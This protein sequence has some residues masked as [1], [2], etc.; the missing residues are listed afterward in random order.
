MP[1]LIVIL[2]L[3]DIV[4]ALLSLAVGQY[5]RLDSLYELQGLLDGSTFR[6]FLYVLIVLLACYFCELYAVDRRMPRTE[7]A[8]RLSVAMMVAFFVLSALFYAVP[9][10]NLGR[11]VLSLSLLICGTCQFLIHLACLSLQKLPHLAQRVLILG[12]GPLAESIAQVLP[13]SAYNYELAGFV[14]PDN[15]KSTVAASRVIGSIDDIEGILDREKINMLIVSI[16]EKRGVLPVRNLLSCKLRG[17]EIIDSPSFYE[18]LTGKLMVENIQ[19]SWF[20]YADGFRITPFKR[21]WKRALDILFSIIGI[22]IALPIF[23]VV[24]LLIKIFSTG[25]VLYRQ[26]RV[27]EGGC[28]FTLLKFRT[29]CNDAERETGAV[30]AS[31]NDPRI[32]RVGNFLRKSRIDEIPQLFNVLKGEMSFIGPRPERREFVEQLSEKIPYYGKRHFIKPGVTGWAQVRYPYGASENDALEKLR[33]DLYYMKNF[34]ITLDLMIVLE[35]VKVVLFGR[36]GR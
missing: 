31:E 7:L 22:I 36:G 14:R 13:L 24:A 3:G 15:D 4:A 6:V 34:S 35:T 25:P 5:L 26:S 9:Q 17:V 32:T 1:N 10:I 33:Y 19:P 11:G 16:T 20:L 30:W 23:P 2:I 8:S 12:V 27:G 28:E 21:F 18:K 29:M